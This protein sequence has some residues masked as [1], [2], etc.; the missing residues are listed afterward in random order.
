VVNRDF[1]LLGVA[2]TPYPPLGVPRA[3]NHYEPL[4][5]PV[6]DRLKVGLQRLPT[7][8]PPGSETG[9]GIHLWGWGLTAVGPLA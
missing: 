3:M 8:S 1:P 9:D 7:V 4:C 5:V 2:P 6:D